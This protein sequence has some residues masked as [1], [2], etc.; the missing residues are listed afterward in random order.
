MGF[1][2]GINTAVSIGRTLGTQSV[3]LGRHDDAGGWVD[4]NVDAQTGVH[5]YSYVIDGGAATC[6]CYRDTTAAGATIAFTACDFG[7]KFDVC[8]AR[9]IA[10][11]D[12]A[13]FRFA[14]W[15]SVVSAAVLAKAQ[16]WAVRL[17]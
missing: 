12:G 8:T 17:P 13:F 3:H 4:S 7:N 10:P 1:F 9:T 6:L 2:T 14:Y 5:A 11:P 15:N 16:A